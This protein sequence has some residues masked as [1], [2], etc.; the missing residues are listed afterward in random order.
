[1]G[2]RVVPERK[3][4][5]MNRFAFGAVCACLIGSVGALLMVTTTRADERTRQPMNLSQRVAGKSLSAGSW[6]NASTIQV[7][8]TV[9]GCLMQHALRCNRPLQATDQPAGQASAASRVVLM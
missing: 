5:R 7:T 4:R 9:R 2:H 8:F 6:T 3:D 1:M